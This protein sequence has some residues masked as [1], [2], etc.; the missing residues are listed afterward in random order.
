ML[1]SPGISLRRPVGKAIPEPEGDE[2][3][4]V[5]RGIARLIGLLQHGSIVIHIKQGRI[6]QIETTEK[7]RL[8]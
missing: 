6:T 5:L 2:A 4:E 7:K 1:E 3:T 8:V